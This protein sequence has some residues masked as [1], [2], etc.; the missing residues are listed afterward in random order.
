MSVP[1]EWRH[2]EFARVI[3]CKRCTLATDPNL[4]RDDGENVPQP[5]YIGPH[6][7]TSRVLLIGR[8]PG[9]TK[10]L[11]A[12]DRQYTAAL[13]ALRDDP[14]PER[15]K[16]LTSILKDFIPQWQIHKYF[17]LEDSGLALEDVAYCNIVRCRTT[18][19][20]GPGELLAQQCI[21]EHF[22]RWLTLLAPKIVVFVNKAAW[23]HGYSFVE[24]KGI[25]CPFMNGKRSLSHTDRTA[26][27]EA[28]AALIR[29]YR[30]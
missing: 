28:V 7:K 12:Q 19:D 13:R 6:Y 21:H 3:S 18:G 27:R 22:K 14:T 15:Y 26:N 25:P 24:A 11:Q 5:G 30:G 8:N 17:P 2:T 29:Q 16:K 23:S 1:V 20:S 10:T 9:T 4:L